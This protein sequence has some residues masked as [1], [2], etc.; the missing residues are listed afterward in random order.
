MA[1]VPRVFRVV[2]QVTR[3]GQSGRL[4]L[5]VAGRER[6]EDPRSPSLLRLRQ[7][8][9]RELKEPELPASERAEDNGEVATSSR[10][11]VVGWS[12]SDEAIAGSEPNSQPAGQ[13]EEDVGLGL[14][15]HEVVAE[16]ENPTL[17]LGSPVVAP[18][19]VESVETARPKSFSPELGQVE[20]QRGG[21]PSHGVKAN[22]VPAP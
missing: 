21:R 8:R 14:R 13:V 4:L 10:K 19:V 6:K 9:S 12:G 7:R 17:P 20:S 1:D 15:E 5:K 16:Q 3:P 2:L 22:I 18:S 11:T